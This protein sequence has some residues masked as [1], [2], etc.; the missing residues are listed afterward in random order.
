MQT[1]LHKATI[2]L[3]GVFLLTDIST[4]QEHSHEQVSYL[5]EK[6]REILKK[7]S[8]MHGPK[9]NNSDLQNVTITLQG[10]DRWL[11]QGK[12]P[13]NPIRVRY[14]HQNKIHDFANNRFYSLLKTR[15]EFEKTW[16]T[17][18]VL[19]ASISYT[20]D[21]L[22]RKYQSY[23]LSNR[24]ELIEDIVA[25]FPE[26][27]RYIEDAMNHLETVTWKQQTNENGLKLDVITFVDSNSNRWELS[28]DS[29][30]YL[31][32]KVVGPI[33]EDGNSSLVA[34]V[35]EQ[36][37][38][39]YRKINDVNIP[40]ER[41]KLFNTPSPFESR[42]TE[43]KVEKIT[44]NSGIDDSIFSKPANIAADRMKPA[45]PWGHT[46]VKSGIHL[47]EKVHSN[48]NA[49][50]IELKD[51]VIL[52][53]APIDDRLSDKL[54]TKIDSL[55]PGKP[56]KYVIASHFHYD[57]IGGLNAYTNQ[58]ASVIAP[59]QINRFLKKFVNDIKIKQV[60]NHITIGERSERIEIYEIGDN[61]HSE[62]MLYAY[63]PKAKA[64][65]VAD[66]LWKEDTGQL[67]PARVQTRLFYQ[68]I[69]KM[70]GEVTTLIPIHGPLISINDLKRSL[71]L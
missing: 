17:Q 52:F 40:Y 44:F 28:I 37:Y 56:I 59:H 50:F 53:D 63:I 9:K 14:Y 15:N 2:V 6:A 7:T 48:Y 64:V 33:N 67:R 51:F 46:E 21:C 54:I 58:G 42:F 4:A 70:N 61:P 47:I 22:S 65:I 39:D 69:D 66:L 31:I 19:S 20:F 41:Y 8:T 24:S 55:A 12:S 11:G 36:T 16:C 29:E 18:N 71:N 35:I 26:P 23:N 27:R 45:K 30:Q 25:E 34:P 10:S 13:E 32:K 62:G 43:L 38:S 49:V 68:H 5:Q 3:L 60:E 57:H 1:I